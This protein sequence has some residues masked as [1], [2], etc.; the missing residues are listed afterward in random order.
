MSIATLIMEAGDRLSGAGQRS[1]EP[2]AEKLA[3]SDPA[4][5]RR[6]SESRV[7]MVEPEEQLQLVAQV[8]V[9][10]EA[11]GTTIPSR[12]DD[13]DLRR[14]LSS[15]KGDVKTC[16]LRLKQHIEWRMAFRFLSE[17]EL[18]QTWSQLAF[19]HAT[20]S[21][22]RPFLCLRFGLAVNTILPEQHPVFVQA[23]VSQ[24]EAG[25]LRMHSQGS[26]K[27]VVFV[28]CTGVQLLSLPLA[29]IK[30][31]ALVLQRNYPSRLFALYALGVHPFLRFVANAILQ[32]LPAVTRDK[33]QLL[34]SSEQ[35]KVLEVAMGGLDKV[36]AALGG[37]EGFQLQ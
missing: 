18:Q 28:D 8:K 35:G 32:I 5:E 21:M 37:R 33:V 30:D 31:S 16:A 36:P 7:S 22:G 4:E 17:D 10:L 13:D 14:F 29:L 19:W 2:P 3:S 26:G 1:F 27:V 25:I 15:T 23:V 20:D 24:M 12:L 9:E 34:S 6:G 11:L